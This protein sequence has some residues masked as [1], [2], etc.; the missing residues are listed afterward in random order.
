L[1][2][3]H[4]KYYKMCPQY[5]IYSTVRYSKAL[6]I[7][8]HIDIGLCLLCADL[9][10]SQYVSLREKSL[11]I[12]AVGYISL[13]HSFSGYRWILALFPRVSRHHL[14]TWRRIR[15][16]TGNCTP[17]T[18]PCLPRCTGGDQGRYNVK[19]LNYLHGL[20]QGSLSRVYGLLVTRVSLKINGGMWLIGYDQQSIYNGLICF[21]D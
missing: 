18:L 21:L 12:N 6:H 20:R 3:R 13:W 19:V 5:Y 11:W 15:P 17:R 9:M 14:T 16:G 8:M 2:R 1:P 7:I 10:Q 4:T